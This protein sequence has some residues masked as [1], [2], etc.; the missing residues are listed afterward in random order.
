[1]TV[2][3]YG[4]ESYGDKFAARYDALHA[5]DP[6]AIV[7]RLAELAGGG[8]VL[9]LGI[10]TGRI[11]LPLCERGIEVHG[12]DASTR[13]ID[14][15]REKP[16]G[17][18]IPITIG[19]FADVA[20]E[21]EFSLIFIAFN[22]IFALLTQEDQLRCFRNVAERLQPGGVFVIEAFVPDLGRFERGQNVSTTRLEETEA[23]L[24]AS[25][26]DPVQQRV[27]THIVFLSDQGV[28]I[29]PLKLRYAW[30]SEL[31]LMARLAGL[32][33][34]DRWGG[35]EKEPFSAESGVHISVYEAS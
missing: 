19:D 22:T 25:V 10:G 7:N 8:R 35:W 27:D 14:V 34:R 2:S 15:L 33:L 23:V 1:V 20:V 5:M 29:F 11:A 32:R 31:D 3:E 6:T 18:D 21:G 9:E 16:G 4:P 26:H 13:M 28:E 24:E 30:P 17:E 12:V